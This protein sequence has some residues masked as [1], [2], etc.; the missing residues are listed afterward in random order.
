VDLPLALGMGR[1]VRGRD[2]ADKTLLSSSPEQ[3]ARSE[4]TYYLMCFR[5]CLECQAI[6]LTRTGVETGCERPISLSYT[7]G[8]RHFG[9]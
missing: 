7:R 9:N 1:M 3:N 2:R 4:Q 8:D 5:P 6:L